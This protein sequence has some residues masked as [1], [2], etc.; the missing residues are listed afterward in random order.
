MYRFRR[1]L[2][3]NSRTGY[4]PF[5]GIVKHGYYSTRDVQLSGDL[6]LED[7]CIMEMKIS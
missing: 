2:A 6:S 7:I 3:I 5:V 4:R 1:F